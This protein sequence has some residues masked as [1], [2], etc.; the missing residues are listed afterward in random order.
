MG[1]AVHGPKVVRASVASSGR[2]G[3]FA[4]ILHDIYLGYIVGPRP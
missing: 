3:S 2:P 1:K 4:F